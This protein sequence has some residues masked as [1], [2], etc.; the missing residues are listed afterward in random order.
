M[1]AWHAASQVA[2]TVLVAGHSMGRPDLPMLDTRDWV[3]IAITGLIGLGT[4][5]IWVIFPDIVYQLPFLYPRH[6]AQLAGTASLL[7]NL[8]A[9]VGDPKS[10]SPVDLSKHFAHPGP[11]EGLEWQISNL[12]IR[13]RCNRD[14]LLRC[15][16][17]WM[18]GAK[19]WTAK[20]RG[21]GRYF[22]RN[23][24]DFDGYVYVVCECVG[25][26]ENQTV[27]W[28]VIY[29]LKPKEDPIDGW[30]GNWLMFSTK[31]ASLSKMGQMDLHHV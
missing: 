26:C 1:V 25:H 31:A 29:Q 11:N 14:A 17:A 20:V 6:K 28:K 15:E 4:S 21:K 23:V 13:T 10:A 22:P 5:L 7:H 12:S 16:L 18:Q 24:E 19:I 2:S 9:K 3:I 8:T 27:H 30:E